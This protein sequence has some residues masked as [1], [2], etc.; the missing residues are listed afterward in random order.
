MRLREIFGLKKT[1]DKAKQTFNSHAVDAWAMATDITG[2]EQ[3]TERGMF[4]WVP[5][6]LHRRQLHRLQA[7]A[8]GERKPYGGTQS[9]GLKRGTLIEHVKYGLTYIGGMQRKIKRVSLHS[10]ETGKRLT[11]N[12]KLSDLRILTTIT[13]RAQFL[14]A[15]SNGVSLRKGL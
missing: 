9:Y 1:K 8:G 15:T 4:Y 12:A 7:S 6:R 10:I 11:Q 2:A 13:W 5:I 14:P 3:P